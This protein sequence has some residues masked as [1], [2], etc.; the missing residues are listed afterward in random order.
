MRDAIDHII[1]PPLY[2]YSLL[3]NPMYLVMAY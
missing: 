1:T 3:T 2:S